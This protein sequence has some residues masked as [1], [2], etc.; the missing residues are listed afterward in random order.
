MSQQ[1]DIQ[2]IARAANFAARRHT[3][4]RRKG[5]AAE[6]YVNHLAQV[7]MLLADAG[8]DANLVAAGYLHD[9]ME[10]QAVTRAELV[11]LCNADVAELVAHVTDDTALPK[12]RRKRLQ[13]EHAPYLPPRAQM[14]KMADK[15]SNLSALLASP[16]K[17]W[18]AQRRLAY[19]EWAREVV[20]GCRSAHAG[21]AGEFDELYERR[22][23]AA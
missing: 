10:D 14:L 17:D 4:Q 11:E 23:L 1:T 7:A 12:E 9:T 18:T 5:E 15:I 20:E 6:P 3:G 16:P 13:V 21:L 2:V 19:F 8:A 22:G